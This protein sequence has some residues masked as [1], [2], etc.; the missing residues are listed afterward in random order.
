MS[1]IVGGEIKT[2]HLRIFG[3][4]ET[5]SPNFKLTHTH[6]HR[7][8]IANLRNVPLLQI[9]RHIYRQRNAVYFNMLLVRIGSAGL[10]VTAKMR[11]KNH[12]PGHGRRSTA[13]SLRNGNRQSFARNTRSLHFRDFWRGAQV[14]DAN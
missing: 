4:A 12:R 9:H 2:A 3:N 1:D 8:R 6:T 7:V 10:V 11:P 14:I 5:T 13:A